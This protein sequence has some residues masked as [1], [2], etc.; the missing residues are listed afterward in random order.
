LS[1]LV[2]NGDLIFESL[3]LFRDREHQVPIQNW[4]IL[5]GTLTVFKKGVT[6]VTLLQAIENLPD[7][8]KVVGED[9]IVEVEPNKI[10]FLV[11]AQFRY[12][13]QAQEITISD[14]TMNLFYDE[15]LKKPIPWIQITFPKREIANNSNLAIKITLI[16][17]IE[18]LAWCYG[19]QVTENLK[20]TKAM[21]EKDPDW[22]NFKATLTEKEQRNWII[23]LPEFRFFHMKIC[24]C[25]KELR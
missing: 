1:K 13:G 19:V 4:D 20:Q 18:Y 10:S 24:G 11:Y 14:L 9:K 7:P 21:V 17:S 25:A 22:T 3:F 16:R 23:K 6:S 2:L 8:F 12:K 15:L 5:S